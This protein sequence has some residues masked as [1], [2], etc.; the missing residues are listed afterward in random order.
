MSGLNPKVFLLFLALLPQFTDPRGA[1]PVPA[2]MIALGLV[3]IIN[4]LAVYLLVGLG[5][6]FVL[7]ARPRAAQMVGRVSGAAMITLALL[8]LAG[9]F[10][11]G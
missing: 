11:Q 2:Q 6:K 10:T 9:Q 3:H 5:A 1:F 4:C 7:S 8:L